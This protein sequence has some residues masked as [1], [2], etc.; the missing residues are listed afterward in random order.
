[1]NPMKA[2]LKG[3]LKSN[4]WIYLDPQ[5]VDWTEKYLCL[6]IQEHAFSGGQSVVKKFIPGLQISMKRIEPILYFSVWKAK[7][8]QS[9]K[10]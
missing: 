4:Y 2:L 3:T 6:V 10:N 7:S 9:P 8:Q 1:M 5:D